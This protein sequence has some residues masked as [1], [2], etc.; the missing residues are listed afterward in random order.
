M[1][2][3]TTATADRVKAGGIHYTPPDLARFLARLVVQSMDASAQRLRVLDPACGDGS[4]LRAI[5]EALPTDARSRAE[6]AGYDLDPQAVAGAQHALRDIAVREVRVKAGDFLAMTGGAATARQTTL[7]FTMPE[8]RPKSTALSFDAIISNPPYV[9]TQVLGAAAAQRLA[10]EFDL[11][12][13]VDLYHAF[14]KAM[15]PTLRPGGVLGLLTSNRFLV[16]RAGAALREALRGDLEL[17]H[18]VDLG[19][20]KLFSAAVLPVIV[21]GRRSTGSDSGGCSFVRIYEDREPRGDDEQEEYTSVLEA[22]A[23]DSAARFRVGPTSYSI[24]RG[25]LAA[26]RGASEPWTLRSDASHGWT[27]QIEARTACT[28]GDVAKVRVGI[29]TTADAVFMRSDWRQL[30]ADSRPESKLLRPVL[31]HKEVERWTREQDATTPFSVLYPHEVRDERRRTID[32][33]SYPRARQYLESH[34]AR[35]EGREYVRTSGRDWYEI[36]VPHNPLDWARPKLVWPD[37]SERARFFIDSSGSLVNGD[38]YWAVLRPGREEDWLHLMLG[39]ANSSLAARYYDSQFNNRLYAG[40]RRWI[41]QYVERLPL[42]A[43]NSPH[44]LEVIS[45]V[46]QLVECA[47]TG[48]TAKTEALQPA[49]DVAVARAFGLEEEVAR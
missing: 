36:W 39:V 24:E 44:A 37:I 8:S 32:L 49:L 40:R 47:R 9:R 46:K 14:V 15:V 6:L 34:R 13:R 29:K 10:E 19:D 5:A 22:L 48:S 1:A 42:P 41:T 28:F 23:D 2:S 4:L 25:T 26:T 21:I 7:D 30:A 11:S 31:T 3:P 17:V 18:I 43:I 45:L 16:T 35:L 12:G 20:T 33:Q 27:K 38:C